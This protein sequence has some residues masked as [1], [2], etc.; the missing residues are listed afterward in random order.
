MAFFRAAMN[1]PEL[2]IN[3]VHRLHC[4]ITACTAVSMLQPGAKP[5]LKSKKCFSLIP[6]LS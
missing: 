6:T 1:G 5:V 4:E 2:F 3:N